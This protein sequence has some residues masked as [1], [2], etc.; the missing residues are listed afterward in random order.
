MSPQQVAEAYRARPV[1]FRTRAARKLR[2]CACCGKFA[3]TLDRRETHLCAS[4]G[5]EYEMFCNLADVQQS[6]EA[7]AC[8][9]SCHATRQR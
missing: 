6:A 9:L 3:G 1:K 7:L 5:P 2:M 8:F 4:C